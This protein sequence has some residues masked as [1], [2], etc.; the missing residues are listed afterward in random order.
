MLYK[1]ATPSNIKQQ[2]QTVHAVE[3]RGR[4]Y[5]CA[6][7]FSSDNP[8]GDLFQGKKNKIFLK[9]D[10]L[11]SM[12]GD[13]NRKKQVKKFLDKHHKDV[14][15][16][17]KRL[18]VIKFGD[19]CEPSEMDYLGCDMCGNITAPLAANLYRNQQYFADGIRWPMTIK[20]I[21]RKNG[22][23]KAAAE[24]LAGS[25]RYQ[26]EDYVNKV[27]KGVRFETHFDMSK[28]LKRH[29]YHQLYLLFMSMPSKEFVFHQII[30]YRNEDVSK[31]ASY[32]AFLDFELYDA[33][34]NVQRFNILKKIL[35]RYANICPSRKD[36]VRIEKPKRKV[37]RPKKKRTGVK[38]ASVVP[39]HILLELKS[40]KDMNRP[41]NKAKITRLA[42][43]LAVE[44]GR[45][46]QE[47]RKSMVA[48]MNR[49]W[50]EVEK[51]RKRK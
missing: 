24:V 29:L 51:K 31:H 40:R 1:D 3:H 10:K 28:D 5:K 27:L 32:M 42:K 2:N 7:L 15:F 41:V 47:L 18:E 45:D 46:W 8:K 30:I 35:A 26:V 11:F 43:K 44:V 6:F 33:S 34:K 48:G 4:N 23:A 37:G 21:N 17:P 14:T 49:H 25:I 36:A 13:D 39:F 19:Y 22:A 9:G 16:I 38:K 20:L 50:T 12:E